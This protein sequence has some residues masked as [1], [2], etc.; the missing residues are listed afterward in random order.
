MPKNDHSQ[1]STKII[2]TKTPPPLRPPVDGAAGVIPE[3][4]E[5]DDE[6]EEEELLLDDDELEDEAVLLLERLLDELELLDSWTT[7]FTAR[8]G[9]GSIGTTTE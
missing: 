3:E 5:L 8:D 4:D 9:T 1:N 2:E 6:D 7:A